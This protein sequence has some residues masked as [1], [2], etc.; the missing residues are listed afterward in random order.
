MPSEPAATLTPTVLPAAVQEAAADWRRTAARPTHDSGF[1]A[2]GDLRVV[3][4]LDS[5]GDRRV[6]LVTDVGAAAG[7]AA[8]AL[9]HSSPEKA[10]SVDAVI[11]DAVSGAPYPM[12]VQTDLVSCVWM[13]QL[14]RRIG[15]ID[16]AEVQAAVSRDDAG[17]PEGMTVGSPLTGLADRRWAF[18][19]TEGRA[20]RCLTADA[21]SVL[22]DRFSA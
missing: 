6:V 1:V 12:V 10:A 18:K 20:L 15:R 17:M 11:G 2:R 13:S 4:P 22:L 7:Y 8:V 3:S 5:D 16:P 9:V 19:E 14:G 21:V